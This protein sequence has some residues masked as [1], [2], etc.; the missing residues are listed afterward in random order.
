M[1]T[2]DRTAA[3]RCTLDGAGESC[4][5]GIFGRADYEGPLALGRHT[6][7]VRAVTGSDVSPA[8][9]YSWTVAATP[10]SGDGEPG[11]GDGDVAVGGEASTGQPAAFDI[12]GDVTGLVPGVPRPI[13]LTLSN[14]NAESIFVTAVAVEIA[15]E[16]TPPG[17]PSDPNIALDQ[18]SGITAASPVLVP[19]HGSVVVTTPP[20]AAQIALVER[21]W[22]QDVCKGKSFALSYSGS[23][24]S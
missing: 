5:S 16:S 24:H 8:A 23:A 12:S 3:F 18:P 10:T 6:F 4:G 20:R 22:N 14:P 13:V 11:A 19:G 15:A 7:E 9:S 21:P 1:F 2:Y 17:C